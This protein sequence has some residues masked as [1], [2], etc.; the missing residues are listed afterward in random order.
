M[1]VSFNMK[2]INWGILSTGTIAKKFA[3]TI[4]QLSD[5]RNVVAIASRNTET[6]NQLAHDYHISKAY[7]IM[8][9]P[10]QFSSSKPSRAFAI[11]H[12]K[13]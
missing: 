4:S 3:I 1:K 13:Y 5:C 9:K 7:K 11:F 10:C 8:E 6:A 2:S 12:S